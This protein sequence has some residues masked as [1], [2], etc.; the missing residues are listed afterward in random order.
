M[1]S[2]TFNQS[3]CVVSKQ[4]KKLK[5]CVWYIKRRHITVKAF[6]TICY[7]I[8]MNMSESES[9]LFLHHYVFVRNYF[10]IHC[11]LKSKSAPNIVVII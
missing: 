6:Y 10:L 4:K 3:D 5:Y 1:W 2:H 7:S 8:A 11:Y 9:D